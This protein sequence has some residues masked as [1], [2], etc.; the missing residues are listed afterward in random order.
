MGRVFSPHSSMRCASFMLT[1]ACPKTP[2]GF[3]ALKFHEW[4]GAAKGR[5]TPVAIFEASPIYQ[6]LPSTKI[7]SNSEC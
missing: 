5:S 3:G 6:V 7:K 4:Q 2:L 1:L